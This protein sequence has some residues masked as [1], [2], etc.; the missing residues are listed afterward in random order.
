MNRFRKGVEFFHA[1]M[2]SRAVA[3]ALDQLNNII[4]VTFSSIEQ[5]EPFNRYTTLQSLYTS[6]NH[7]M[8][9]GLMSQQKPDRMHFIVGK[10][11]DLNLQIHMIE[12][13]C[14]Q[15]TDVIGHVISL[16]LDLYLEDNITRSLFVYVCIHLYS[17]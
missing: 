15:L 8:K 6:L 11:W 4:D 1:E 12:K 13:E 16:M 17:R 9:D 5:F 7:Q 2:A 3:T 14:A 10:L